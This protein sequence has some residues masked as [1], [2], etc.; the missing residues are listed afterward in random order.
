M[1]ELEKIL[2]DQLRYG[3]L[4][5]VGDSYDRK[6]AYRLKEKMYGASRGSP[7]PVRPE[8]YDQDAKSKVVTT[9]H[10]YTSGSLTSES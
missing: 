5:F 4:C 6:R 7:M 3:M 8:P 9:R 1:R 2:R 10:F